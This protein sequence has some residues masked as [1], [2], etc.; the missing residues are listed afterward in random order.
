MTHT[1]KHLIALIL[2]LVLLLPAAVQ[3][4]TD[5]PENGILPCEYT[6]PK[7]AEYYM[8]HLCD[9]KYDTT[10]TLYRGETLTVQFPEGTHVDSLF[11][12]F[13]TLP[14]SYELHYYDAEGKHIDFQ[15]ERQPA[16][17]TLIPIAEGI[18]RV[19]IKATDKTLV[20]CECYPCT[21]AY[22][23]LFPD[24]GDHADVLIV[25]NKPGDELQLLGGLIAQLAGEHGL[26]VQVDYLIKTDGY[27]TRQCMEI[28]RE[29]GVTRLPLFGK[30]HEISVRNENAVYSALGSHSEMLRRFVTRIRTLKPQLVLT[31]D[32][33]LKQE[34]YTDGV[35]ARTVLNAVEFAADASRYP[36]TEA[37]E[38]QKVYTLSPAGGTVLSM[39]EPLFAYN[40][41]TADALA[42]A[43]YAY[44]R[45]ER[46]F[47][48]NMPDT[49]RFTLAQS[50]V[51]EDSAC[52]DL[53]EHLATESFAGYRVP[54]PSPSPTPEPTDTPEP[55]EAPTVAP[56]VKPTAAATV[57]PT[58][59]PKR[60]LL[61]CAGRE[62]TPVPTE[63]PTVEPT[64]APTPEPTEA[65]T[66]EPTEVPTPEPT[67]DPNDAYFLAGD[68]EEYDLDFDNGHWWYKNN[69]LSIDIERLHRTME[70]NH[71][72]VYYVAHIRMREY[73]SY[74]SGVK[75]VYYKP[76]QY[77]RSEKAVFAITGDN[78]ANAD[79]DRKGCL[80][81][82]G[83]F[84]SNVGRMDTMVVGEDMTLRILHPEEVVARALL[85]HG[86]R[87]TYSFGPTLVENGEI[88][89][90]VN[91]H[92]VSQ[93]S[94]R[95]GIGMVEP[96]YWIAI[97]TDGRLPE[98]SYSIKLDYFAQL[99]RELGCTVAYNLDGGSSV[100]MCIMGETINKHIPS[101]DVQ[102]LWLDALMFGYSEQ[103]PDVDT[104]TIHDG[105]Y[106]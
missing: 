83:V 37:F 59:T 15:W 105:Y 24:V 51:G 40:A 14:E 6:V 22:V 34:R 94:P 42:D 43:L 46:V 74:R 82:K 18:T 58:P 55:T 88:N 100:A 62:E 67:P 49:V 12:D 54:T 57:E 93:A 87:D 77:T 61:S 104:P 79:K 5:A 75:T 64:E 16:Y 56:I 102:R 23:P 2:I 33:N 21:D 97:V 76:H 63:A 47:R 81:R 66:P 70:K 11:L 86:I 80:I 98:Y 17:Q 71:P 45:E 85:D 89:P 4:G 99:F 60:G 73:T 8:E 10:L 44:Y 29:M 25:L 69:V 32:A 50:T 84:Y 106:R 101:I 65:P 96:G 39:N 27:H 35:I 36:G 26:S 28:L 1:P 20:L 72:L 19:M 103:L 52:N 91:K 95:C 53:L 68:G 3:A 48:R 9:G 38:V 13:Y 92:F 90:L 78:I 30:G 31:L 41:V 7:E